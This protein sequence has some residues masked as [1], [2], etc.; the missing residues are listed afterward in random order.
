MSRGVLPTRC[1][2][3]SGRS[4]KRPSRPCRAARLEDDPVLVCRRDPRPRDPACDSAIHG[5]ARKRE[6]LAGEG[7]TRSEHVEAR[8]DDESDSRRREGRRLK[9]ARWPAG[10][11]RPSPAELLPCAIA[12]SVSARS[13][14]GPARSRMLTGGGTSRLAVVRSARGAPPGRDDRGLRALLRDPVRLRRGRHC[15]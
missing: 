4:Q 3:R 1:G 11:S 7:L 8:R 10:R 2:Q 13:S 5:E 9:R 14:W 6:G 12:S 15:C